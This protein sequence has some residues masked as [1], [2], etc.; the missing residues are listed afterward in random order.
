MGSLPGYSYISSAKITGQTESNVNFFSLVTTKDGRVQE[1][2]DRGSVFFTK[3]CYVAQNI[4][5]FNG[6]NY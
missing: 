1:I 5:L 6:Q 2:S 3:H 4:Q